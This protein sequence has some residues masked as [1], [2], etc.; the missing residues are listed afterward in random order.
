MKQIWYMAVKDLRLLTRDKVGLFFILGF[1]VLMGLFFG[2]IMGGPSEGGGS[3]MRLAVVDEDQSEL[4]GKFIDNLQDLGNVELIPHDRQT[5]MEKV[6]KGQLVGMLA[7]PEG[8]GETAGLPWEDTPPIDLGMDPSRSAEA[9]MAEGFV[10]QSMGKLMGD[11]LFDVDGMRPMIDELRESLREESDLVPEGLE[12]VYQQLV[13]SLDTMFDSIETLENEADSSSDA[14]SEEDVENDFSLNFANINRIDV[15]KELEKGSRAELISRLRSKWDITFPQAMVWG[16]L[17]CVAGFSVSIV[18]ERTR[19]TLQR[20]EVAPVTRFQIL[21]GKGLACFL[22][23]LLVILLLTLFGVSLGM[24][25]RSIPY[26]VLAATVIAFC[27]VGIMMTIANV[28]RTEEAV[29]GAGW[30]VCM[31]MAMFGGGMVPLMFLPSFM[32]PLSKLSPIYWSVLSI[33]GAIWRGFS[34]SE[35]LLPFTVLILVGIAGIVFGTYQ[36]GKASA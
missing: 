19:G 12:D 15:T 27:F 30:G 17:G 31:I 7:V 14:T 16:I 23:V 3:K 33:E 13:D 28:G 20:L 11:R 22:A 21:A 18:R 35:F 1:P 4:S 29:S 9:A 26:L 5:A 34:L 6:R 24:R 2:S 25:P 8:F 32:R 10:M 36:L